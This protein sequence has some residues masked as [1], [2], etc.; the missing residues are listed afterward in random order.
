MP[1]ERALRRKAREERD[2]FIDDPKHR[3]RPGPDGKDPRDELT[4][5][6]SLTGKVR[7]AEG[8]QR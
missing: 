2:R 8:E 3:F 6:D 7:P 5:Q 4:R 1:S